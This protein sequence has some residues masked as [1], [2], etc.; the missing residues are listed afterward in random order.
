MLSLGMAG[1]FVF[2]SGEIERRI[3]KKSA[4]NYALGE[5]RQDRG[6]FVPKY[7]GRSDVDLAAELKQRL[8]ADGHLSHFEFSYAPSPRAA[9]ATECR[10]FH[11]FEAQLENEV[12]PD[13][14]DGASWQCPSC[15]AFDEDD[16]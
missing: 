14:P 9:F 3:T 13:R 12:H 4:G 2:D 5:I 16:D 1:P 7:V 6:T 8:A 10:T 15:D 11:D